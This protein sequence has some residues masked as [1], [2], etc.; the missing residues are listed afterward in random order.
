MSM[1]TETNE[2]MMAGNG[3]DSL[4]SDDANSGEN[5]W[6]NG[7]MKKGP[8]TAS[9]DSILVD[10]VLKH[11]EGNWNAV[12]KHTGLAR[13]GKSCRLRWANHL[14]PD[15]KKGA[16][17]TEEENRIIELH[18]KLGNK[19]ARMAAELPG[20]TDNEIKNYWNT[21]IKRRQRAGLPIY[22]PG[23]CLEPSNENQQKDDTSTFSSG[24]LHCRDFIN[25]N[26]IEIPAVN[27]KNLDLTPHVLS[28]PFL[29]IPRSS[30]LA[31]GLSSTC[32]K[33]LLS[34]EHPAK[35]FRGSNYLYNGIN[36]TLS[37]SAIPGGSQYQN[38]IY[39][40]NGQPF[41]YTCA[42]SSS[43]AILNDNPSSSKPNWAKKQELPSLQSQVD[44]WASPSSPLPSLESVD[45]LIQTPP[46]EHTL[47]RHPSPQNSGLLDA[48]LHEAETMKISRNS[49]HQESSNASN[50]VVNVIDTSSQVIPDNRW[51][52]YGDISTFLGHSSS[53]CDDTP[54]SGN[55]FEDPESLD[56][57]TGFSFEDE[58]EADMWARMQYDH[59]F[60]KGHI[61]NNLV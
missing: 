34:T 33:T 18:A 46:T 38:E 13:C 37:S 30:L 35:R 5:A 6:G 42:S 57:I 12:Q 39:V 9:E 26:E 36:A 54:L 60:Q 55:S 8:W 16:F 29:D 4:A 53:F 52:Q 21:R 44:N 48:V 31:Q 51:E 17:S 50:M 22:P 32:Q 2:E 3:K 20:R 19:W 10:Y 14:R 7:Q 1:T 27:F 49:S 43:V 45:A 47:P 58:E 11:G 56:A 61:N 59:K 40:Q 28:L 41:T 25:V 15:L 23:I 24:V